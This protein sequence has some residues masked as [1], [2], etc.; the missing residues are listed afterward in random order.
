[1]LNGLEFC[2]LSKPESTDHIQGVVNLNS[3]NIF[4]HFGIEEDYITVVRVTVL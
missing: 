4:F 1:M 3:R 2:T